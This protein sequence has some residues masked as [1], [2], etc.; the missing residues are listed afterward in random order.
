MARPVCACVA[1]AIILLAALGA[2]IA[3]P[4][5]VMLLHSFGREVKPWTDYAQSIHA[6]LARQSPWPLDVVDYALV[7]AR[8]ADEDPELPF[9][10][11]LRALYAKRP[12]DLVVSVGA[13]AA[14]FVQRHRQQ[15]FAAIPMV[16]T[17]VEQRRVQYSI[18]TANDAVVPLRIN[19]VAAM[20]NILRVLPDTKNVAVVVGTSPIEQ[21]WR[22][23]I[24]K[25]VAPFTDRI[26]F[27][28][29]D[30]LPFEEILKHAA[31]LPP[32]SAIVWELM[33]VDA[34]GVVHDGDTAFKRLRAAAN[35]PIFG[36]YEANLGEGVVGGPYSAVLDSSR[37]TAAVA[38]R[39]L[40]G[41]RAG[42]IRIA[43]I[44]FA[45][46]K[47]D[48]REMQRWGISEARL[49]AGSEILF[50]DPSAWEQYRWQIALIAAVI[51]LQ[52][53]LITGLL[54]EH[55]RR[56][57]AEVEARNRLSEL[58]HINRRATADELSASIA[59]E[60]NQPLSAILANAEAAESMLRS[61]SPKLDEIK[62]ILADIRRD[63][64][65]ASEV[66]VRLRRLLTKKATDAQEI[67]INE[68]VREVLRFLS[69]QA[70]AS[71]VTLGSTLVPEALPVRGDRVQLQQVILNLVVNAMEAA[72]GT[73][74][75]Q[76]KVTARTAPV[77]GKSVEVS[78][79]DTGPG[80]PPDRLKD[81]FQPFF[82]T[83][84]HG[85]GMGLSIART[86]VEAHEGR[87]WAENHVGGGAIFRLRLPL[88][89]AHQE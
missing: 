4:K 25:D 16:F 37:A 40:G 56:R 44:E 9:V 64:E 42:D 51:L 30:N 46:P 69:V 11:Y 14:G 26:A 24:R 65:R 48:W 75:G 47:F 63:D 13:P 77:D 38:V 71:H 76:R 15:L 7:S 74:N 84:E 22:D 41:E 83:K 34:A 18:L 35:A 78:I 2:A 88:A 52:A 31:A 79:A 12:L 3:E 43:P 29:Y 23:E 20:E 27:T 81:V 36:Y 89:Q 82:T 17:V 59:H 8:S 58:A 1:A 66:I 67:D 86:I 85:M 80:I 5:R 32:H 68:T 28:F 57:L 21:F 45:P 60:L 39:I 87:I 50:R 19:Y 10:E 72:V 49:P 53:A 33:I 73:A 55:R 6:E 62:D 61:A 70:G 54:Y